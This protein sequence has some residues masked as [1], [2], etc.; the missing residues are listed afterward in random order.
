MASINIDLIF[1]EI[2][3]AL[4]PLQVNRREY[5]TYLGLANRLTRSND[6]SGLL[7][8]LDR[9]HAMEA[10][11]SVPVAV[12]DEVPVSEED[13]TDSGT[14]ESEATDP[15]DPS[16]DLSDIT[17]PT[18]DSTRRPRRRNVSHNVRYSAAQK[19]VLRH[20]F[21]VVKD[22]WPSRYMRTMLGALMDVP[23]RNIYFWFAN[24]RRTQGVAKNA[25]HAQPVLTPQQERQYLLQYRRDVGQPNMIIPLLPSLNHV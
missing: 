9:L 22:H 7:D 19:A 3:D 12:E 13:L 15:Q 4:V 17:T 2:V 8:L 14:E 11:P 24:E 16:Q 20:H 5:V 1:E 23:P 6:F 21:Y 10:L 25:D 18:T